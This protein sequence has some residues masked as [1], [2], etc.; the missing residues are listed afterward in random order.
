MVQNKLKNILDKQAYTRYFFLT[1]LVMLPNILL[2]LVGRDFWF[3]FWIVLQSIMLWVMLTVIVSNVRVLV[4]LTIP[5]LL[6][7]PAECYFIYT[8]GYPSTKFVVALLTETSWQELKQFLSGLWLILFVSLL[9]MAGSS[10]WMI[11]DLRPVLLVPRRFQVIG[12]TLFVII[13]TCWQVSRYQPGAPLPLRQFTLANSF[14]VG[15]G[16]RVLSYAKSHIEGLKNKQLVQ[17]H[18]FGASSSVLDL[19]LVLVIG[20][21]ARPDHWGMNGYARNTTPKLGNRSDVH[22]MT[23]LI[24]PWTL[25]TYSTPLFITRKPA[26]YNGIFPEKSLLAA[27]NDAGFSTYWVANQDGLKEM[28]LHIGEAGQRKSFNFAVRGDVDAVFD[29]E[30]LPDIDKVINDKSPKKFIVIH[31][32]GSHWDYHLRYPPEF[33]IFKPDQIDGAS[34]KY[35]PSQ[36]NT[37]VNGYDNSIL[38]TDYFLNE[39]IKQLEHTRKPSA[40]VYVSDHGEGLYENGCKIL[41]HGN[42]TDTNFHTAGLIW[43]SPELSASRPQLESAIGQNTKSPLSTD[44]TIFNTLADLGGLNMTENKYSLLSTK[45]ETRQ[46]LV[47]TS[48]GIIDFDHSSR[49]GSCELVVKTESPHLDLH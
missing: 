11:R 21:S 48:T 10:I 45:F 46:R 35:N 4:M 16:Y 5:F 18:H 20:E 28:A 29:G 41:G 6:I 31:S 22:F 25:T 14:P 27:F 33:R 42:D 23:N 49:D 12:L 19:T 9:V 47:N 15:I 17:H 3:S 7:V 40:M 44:L 2:L 30:M 37:L 26:T 39:L 1:A 36:R 13:I 43:V 38:Y 32:K 34:G 24:T 8:Y